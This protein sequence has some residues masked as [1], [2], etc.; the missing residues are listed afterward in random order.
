MAGH[1]RISQAAAGRPTYRQ[2]LLLAWMREPRGPLPAHPA[3]DWRAARWAAAELVALAGVHGT[4][5]RAC[6][7][8]LRRLQ[9]LGLVERLGDRWS[10]TAEG[11]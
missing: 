1:R 5:R 11:R 10:L 8:D 2:L 3:I 6:L 9:R 4:S 7:D